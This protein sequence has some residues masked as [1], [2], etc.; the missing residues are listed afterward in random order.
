[1]TDMRRYSSSVI[2]PEN[3]HDDGGTRDEA[4]VNISHNEK[5]NCAVL[6]FES[7]D[8]LYLWNDNARILNRA[9]GYESEGW[10]GQQLQLT[11]GHYLDKKTDPPTQKETIV[12]R[13]ISPA[14]TGANGGTLTTKPLPSLKDDMDNSVPF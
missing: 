1:M 3:L 12:V 6:E 11:I 10:I 2:R 9:W 5:Y 14:R 4:I 7:G 13:P 8:Q